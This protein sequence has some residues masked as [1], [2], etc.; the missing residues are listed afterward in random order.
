MTS[1]EG[2][3]KGTGQVGERKDHGSVLLAST[4]PLPPTSPSQPLGKWDIL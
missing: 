4:A 1:S 3:L 2:I